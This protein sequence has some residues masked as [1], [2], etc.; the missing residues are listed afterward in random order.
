MK[1][2]TI[3]FLFLIQ[4]ICVNLVF[5]QN[6]EPVSVSP[7]IGDKLDSIEEEYFRLVPAIE[8]IQEAIFYLNPDSSLNVFVIYKDD[9]LVKD[10]FIV[11]Y[12]SLGRL[13]NYIDYQLNQEI[14]IDPKIEKGKYVNVI[15]QIDSVSGELLSVDR[16]N[17]VVLK[18]S[19][20]DYHEEYK[21]PFDVSYFSD[22]KIENVTVY[23]EYNTA[24]IIYPITLG[25]ALGI[26][27]GVIA[28][29]KVDSEPSKE[30]GDWSELTTPLLYYFLGG[31]VGILIGYGLA[32]LIP[33]TTIS[34]TVY[35]YPFNEDDIEGLSKVSRYK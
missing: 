9:G 23:N 24:K 28:K 34:T 14:K 30:L 31:I 13:R 16:T 32:E 25:L 19:K 12:I 35:D 2:N 11:N 26:T 3:C 27:A 6:E 10:T 18:L 29:N 21:P 5:S 1:F 8:N 33:I 7:V 20:P 17:V 15:A 22:N 4:A